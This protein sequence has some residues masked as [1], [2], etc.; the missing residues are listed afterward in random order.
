V[1]S[2]LLSDRCICKS[3]LWSAV[4]VIYY[5]SVTV[6]FSEN[7][8]F[9]IVKSEPR[10]A[11]TWWYT[12]TWWSTAQLNCCMFKSVILS[13]SCQI[14]LLPV[15][16]T[17]ATRFSTKRHIPTNRNSNVHKTV[18][19]VKLHPHFHCLWQLSVLMCHE[20]GQS[21]FLH[22]QTNLY[23]IFLAKFLGTNSLSVLMYHKAVNQSINQSSCQ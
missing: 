6:G 20:A 5:G 18:S 21:A 23:H 3:Q 10:L 11:S 14:L 4:L 15:Y 16:I 17:I 12:S 19:L 1:L 13:Y 2:E 22:T 9:H 8:S 7:A